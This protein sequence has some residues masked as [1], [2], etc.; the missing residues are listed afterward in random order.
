M[1]DL[2]AL[3]PVLLS[4]G[5]LPG[6]VSPLAPFVSG[7][8]TLAIPGPTG[9]G[10]GVPIGGATGQVLAKASGD[11]YDAAWIDPPAG[12]SATE[13]RSAVD[14]TG[15]TVHY[16]GVAPVGTAEGDPGWTITRI[17]VA[18]SGDATTTTAA[19]PWT[20]REGAFE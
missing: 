20:T 18:P 7:E 19:G 5:L 12:G 17:T 13:V 3:A 8:T 15:S 6:P 2:T 11:D 9:A 16:I 4:T 1:S 10:V 14:S